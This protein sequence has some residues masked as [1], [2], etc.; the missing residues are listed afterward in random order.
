MTTGIEDLF[1]AYTDNNPLTYAFQSGKLDATGDRRVSQLAN[2]NFSIQYQSDRQNADADALSW[3][4]TP[5]I[6]HHA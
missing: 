1:T 6:C 3:I 2:Y 4:R 5:D